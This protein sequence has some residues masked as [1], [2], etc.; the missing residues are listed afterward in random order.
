MLNDTEIDVLARR[1]LAAE[2]ERM[3][4]AI[5][6]EAHAGLSERDAY[7]IQRAGIAL[8]GQRFAG[9]KLGYTSAAMRQQMNIEHPNYGFLSANMVVDEATGAVDREALIHP[10][11]EPEI[12]LL[13]ERDIV[14]PV[15]SRM[16]MAQHVGAVCA[17]L[18]IVD[19]RYTDYQF[20]VQDNIADNSSAARVVLGA[21]VPFSRVTDLRLTG[22]LL[23][24][25]GEVVDQ[26]LG[27][28][29]LGDP[30]LAAIWLA[31]RLLS[32]GAVLPAGSIVLTGGLTRAHPGL[33]GSAFA[34]EFAGLGSVRT[35]FL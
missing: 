17:A 8:R 28:N 14:E 32:E 13:I 10:L 23:W 27:A 30:L 7:A 22:V 11:V 26:G 34:A 15:S 16:A 21:P 9:Y 6:T 1:L 4:T 5:L 12:A 29:A 19:T 24:S 33:R 31:N 2:S 3:P 18:E 20:R 25:N 35:H